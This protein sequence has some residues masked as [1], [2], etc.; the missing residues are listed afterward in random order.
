MSWQKVEA[1]RKRYAALQDLFA[2]YYEREKS[3]PVR[4][5]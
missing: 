5:R 4:S 2:E 3:Q 1:L